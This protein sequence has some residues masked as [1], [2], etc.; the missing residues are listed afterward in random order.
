MISSLPDAVVDLGCQVRFLLLLF[1]QKVPCGEVGIVELR[2]Y[3][4]AL[5]NKEDGK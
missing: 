4:G 3:L 1:P 5:Q 2:S